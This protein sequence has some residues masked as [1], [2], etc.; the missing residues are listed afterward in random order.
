MPHSDPMA[1]PAAAPHQDG[2]RLT[3]AGS[4]SDESDHAYVPQ[5]ASPAKVAVE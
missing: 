3:T 1:A 2:D 4:S 5:R